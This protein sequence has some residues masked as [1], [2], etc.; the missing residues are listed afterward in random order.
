[1]SGRTL[2]RR[3][4]DAHTVRALDD[5]KVLVKVLDTDG[6]RVRTECVVAG[7]VSNNKGG[8]A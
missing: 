2:Y 1:M 7:S 6:V 3:I 5:G 4:V 8:S